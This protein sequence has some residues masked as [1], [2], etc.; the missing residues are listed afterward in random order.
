MNRAPARLGPILLLL[1]LAG[2]GD[3]PRLAPLAAD[4][5]LLAFGDSLTRGTGAA[6]GQSYPALLAGLTGHE[7]INAGVPGEL[8]AQGRTRLPG[9][10]DRYH[11]AL[12]LLCHG[13]NDLLQ[14][15]DTAALKA[16]LRAMVDA[17]RARGIPV[18]LIGVPRPALLLSAEP[19]YGELA[20]ELALP[21]AGEAL[22]GILGDN[23]LKSD[24]VHPNAEGY[25]QLAESLADRLHRLGAL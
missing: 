21:Y 8:S 19:V 20:E 10:L 22:A 16:N 9:L 14:R 3:A 25:R 18:L 24:T 2:C 1:L 12:L 4:A 5:R 15:R 17:A 23:R 7:V 6:P 11:P 13:G